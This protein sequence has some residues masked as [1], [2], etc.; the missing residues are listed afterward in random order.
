[1]TLR[2]KMANFK[3]FNCRPC[4]TENKECPSSILPCLLFMFINLIF[5]PFIL[6]PRRGEAEIYCFTPVCLSICLSVRNFRRSFLSNYSS[7][8]LGIL[9]HSLFW[10]VIRWD[11]FSYESDV[12]SASI[13]ITDLSNYSSLKIVAPYSIPIT[14]RIN[15]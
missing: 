7:Q 2:H 14:Y 12:C 3:W 8:M 15:W 5:Y 10:Y 13:H 1:M 11:S 6:F 4:S 9:A